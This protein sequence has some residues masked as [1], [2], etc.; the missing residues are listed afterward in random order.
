MTRPRSTA[1]DNSPL[2]GNRPGISGSM[3]STPVEHPWTF[4]R[5]QHPQHP[6]F[7]TN[8]NSGRRFDPYHPEFRGVYKPAQ[9]SIQQDSALRSRRDS[10]S[11]SGLSS[12]ALQRSH[13]DSF[14]GS[15]IGHLSGNMS[16][17][18]PK[19]EERIAGGL[20]PGLVLPH[21]RAACPDTRL[22]L[23]AAPPEAAA[24]S[25]A[26]RPPTVLDIPETGR[27]ETTRHPE[28]SQR[29]GSC[30]PMRHSSKRPRN[31]SSILYQPKKRLP[32]P[33]HWCE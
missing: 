1:N 11:G 17:T 32:H 24:I 22:E 15:P 6:R 9:P 12:P 4:L 27:Q 28:P 16:L 33:G 7:W 26:E 14:S 23:D 5:P 10:F 19:R 25:R 3:K 13:R 20:R 18:D 21:P 31:S 8:H 2:A 29:R 30:S